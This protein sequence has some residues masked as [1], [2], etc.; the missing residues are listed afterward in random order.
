MPIVKLVNTS[1]TAPNLRKKS[2]Q[3]RVIKRRAGTGIRTRAEGTTIPRAYQLHYPSQSEV[4]RN[5]QHFPPTW[6]SFITVL[7]R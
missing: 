2:F 6:V 1:T 4:P 3:V 7:I 5:S